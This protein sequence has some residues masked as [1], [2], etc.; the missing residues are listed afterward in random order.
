MQRK[1]ISDWDQ[2]EV[3]KQLPAEILQLKVEDLEL[4]RQ[5][6]VE[7][8]EKGKI[9]ARGLLLQKELQEKKLKSVL[10]KLESHLINNLGISQDD[11][12]KV[13]KFT[14]EE[15]MDLYQAEK[16]I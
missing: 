13:S 9:K 3:H 2:E 16:E 12:N 5:D 7:E 1:D 14:N 4:V 11:I 6:L 10:K 15:L 8:I